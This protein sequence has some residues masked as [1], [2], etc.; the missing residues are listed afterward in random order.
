MT[1]LFSST[2]I[3]EINE[4]LNRGDDI[5]SFNFIF[6]TPLNYHCGLG[7]TNIV[8]LLLTKDDI[9]IYSWDLYWLSAFDRICREG[10]IDLLDIFIN[11]LKIDVNRNHYKRKY[12]PLMHG[13]KNVDVVDKLLVSGAN[14]ND[15]NSSGLTAVHLACINGDLHILDRLIC[16]GGDLRLLDNSNM[17]PLSHA[18]LHNHTD[19]ILRL[20]DMNIT[21]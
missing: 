8:C 19:L 10:H 6:Q 9:D 1:D 20:H 18:K 5:N 11:R 16:Y 12:T 21:D 17:T 4:C 7:N 2:T 3:D 13:I 14:V 15:T